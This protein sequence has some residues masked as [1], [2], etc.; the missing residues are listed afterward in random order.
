ML[1]GESRVER[2]VVH[3]VG[4][5]ARG[6]GLQLSERACDVDDSVSSLILSGYLRGVVSDKKKHQFFHESDLNLNEIYHYTRQFFRDELDFLTVSQRIAK[7]LYARSQHPNISAGDLFVILFAGLSDGERELRALGVF[8]SEVRDDFLSVI[9][10][11]EVF[12][13]RHASGINPRLIDKG[14][15]ILENS[16]L[17]YAVD[18]GG[19]QA[20]FWLDDFLK[21][22][23]VPDANSSSRMV[24]S[25]V[26]QLS[27]EIADPL[28]QARFKDEFLAVCGAEEEMST[29]Q[30]S[31]IAEKFVGKE[32]VSQAFDSAAEAYGF[33]LDEEA[34]LPA[35]N[36]AKRLEK[37]L[38]KYGIGHG[39]SVL[40]PT[41][42]TLKNIQ[43]V[44][45]GE[46]EL[47]LT[48]KLHKRD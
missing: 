4:N 27:E 2:L 24:A 16:P 43:S 15:L 45:D 10:A 31:S 13:I 33:A 12:D 30:V 41:G 14:A 38:S 3:R 47:S 23:R 22:M 40:L 29:G 21:A 8:K 39:I 32:Q 35:Q 5:Q 42:I 9:E 48:L 46:G 28:E 19:Q 26:E 1:I 11:G 20:K 17:V 25:V 37:S 6:E 34:R 7:H 18:R 44:N 36:M